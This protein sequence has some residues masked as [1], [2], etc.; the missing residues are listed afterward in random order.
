MRQNDACGL[1]AAPQASQKKVAGIIHS[2]PIFLHLGFYFFTLLV[3]RS[4]STMFDINTAIQPYRNTGLFKSQQRAKQEA[5]SLKGVRIKE[6]HLL[7]HI[8]DS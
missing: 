5:D 7:G 8:T 4:Y 1:F 6:A 2:A 3:C